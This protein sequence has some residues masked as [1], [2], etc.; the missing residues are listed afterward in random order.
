MNR[1]CEYPGNPS[2]VGK[3][4]ITARLTALSKGKLEIHTGHGKEIGQTT[5]QRSFPGTKSNPTAA[6]QKGGLT[7]HTGHGTEYGQVSSRG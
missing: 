6:T 3:P 1:N 4:S 2:P 5:A 7:I